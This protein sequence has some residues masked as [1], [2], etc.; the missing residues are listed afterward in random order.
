MHPEDAVDKL[1]REVEIIKKEVATLKAEKRRDAFLREHTVA[2]YE[3][4]RAWITPACEAFEM[5]T[6]DMMAPTIVPKEST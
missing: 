4:F 6:D 1:V 5:S 2:E 3:A